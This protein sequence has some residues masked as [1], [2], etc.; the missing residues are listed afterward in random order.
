MATLNL[1]GDGVSAG[2]R[3]Y[4]GEPDAPVVKLAPLGANVMSTTLAS[5]LFTKRSVQCAQ[6]PLEGA[7]PYLDEV[8][9][10]IPPLCRDELADVPRDDVGTDPAVS[11]L[12]FVNTKTPSSTTATTT[13]TPPATRNRA[14]T[15]IPHSRLDRPSLRSMLRVKQ[16]SSLGTIVDWV[17]VLKRGGK[18]TL[19]DAQL[20]ASYLREPFPLA[21]SN[22]ELGHSQ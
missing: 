19:V 10:V 9:T 17:S 3:R 4:P 11:D 6:Y 2:H 5:E 21:P 1:V 8:S 18:T 7:W 12:S 22:R 15:L 20:Q 16:H 14:R 13:T